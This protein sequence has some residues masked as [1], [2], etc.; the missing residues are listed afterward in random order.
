MKIVY[1]ATGEPQ[2]VAVNLKRLPLGAGRATLRVVVPAEL[3]REISEQASI[4][5][6]GLI[7]VQ[8]SFLPWVWLRL[9]MF[10]GFSSAVEIICLSSRRRFRLLKLLALTLRGRVSFSQGN[11][12]RTS[13]TV[14]GLLWG[15]LRWAMAAQ[16]PI[17]VVGTASPARLQSIVANLRRRFPHALLHGVLP[18]AY[19]D[20]P[21]DFNS[22]VRLGRLIPLAWFR[23]LRQCIGR[24]RF[25]RVIV[26]WTGEG[27]RAWKWLGWLLPLWRIEIYNENVDAF[28][29]RNPKLLLRHGW[30]RLQQVRH[31][32][33]RVQQKREQYRRTLPVGVLG[34]AS[35]LSLKK[36]LPVLRARYPGA[37]V[38]GLLPFVLEAP[39]AGSFDSAIVIRSGLRNRLC[40][41]GRLLWESTGFQC[42]IIL[43]TGEGFQGWKWLG[44]LLPVWRIEVYNENADAFPGRNLKLLLRHGWWR[45]Q[46]L[47][48]QHRLRH[49]WWRVQQKREQHR[50]TL[51]VGVIGS[52]SAFYLKK[53]LPVVRAR[54]PGAR[55]HGLL[56]PTLEAPAA[57]LFDS[58]TVLRPGFRNRLRDLGQLIWGSRGFQCWIIPCTNE[59]YGHMKLL[60]FLLPL[61]RRQIY[62][63]QADGFVLQDLRT[64]YRHCLW[65]LRDHLSFQIVASTAGKHPAH[66]VVHLVLYAF[67]LFAGL[68]RLW[69]ARLRSYRMEQ[70]VALRT[71]PQNRGQVD[72]FV[73]EPHGSNCDGGGQFLLDGG[74][75]F[76]RLARL[77]GGSDQLERLQAAIRT[78]QADF[79]CLLDSECVMSPTDWLERLL[80]SFDEHTAQVGPQIASLD[81][82]TF[83]RGLMMDRHGAPLWN[84][85]NAVRWHR[86]PEWLEV[87]AVPWACVLL[88]RSA[89]SPEGLFYHGRNGAGLWVEADFCRRLAGRGWHSL[90]NRNVTAVHPAVGKQSVLQES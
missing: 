3:A 31:W 57:G 10:L 73:L 22:C 12:V 15:R 38:H 5:P 86:R 54:Y 19:G 65:R 42:W 21:I 68:L 58:I 56:A 71:A 14:W 33:W 41:I 66:R 69:E 64:F 77:P 20:S 85:D 87:D 25:Q 11:G 46:Q 81:G 48:E 74:R 16:G 18:P 55:L 49:W 70:N 9:W 62:N 75:D 34:S 24:R 59:P 67:R 61:A 90:C 4:P 39:A 44:W 76:V 26:P 7:R 17:C 84:T 47:R 13:C 37:R 28:P 83:L 6:E 43:W 36:I 88:R 30:W 60:A 72:V 89:L 51:P 32:C 8:L 80:E 23:L 40:D 63:E 35:A 27:F 50:R 82:E 53:I 52:A 1:F 2:E 79:I 78:S 45:L 29:G